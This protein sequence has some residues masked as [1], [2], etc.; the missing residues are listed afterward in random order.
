MGHSSGARGWNGAGRRRRAALG[1]AAI[2][3][4]V[5]LASGLTPPPLRAGDLTQDCH[6]WASASGNARI[7][8]ANQLG[9]DHLLTKNTRLAESDPSKPVELYRFGDLQRLC[10]GT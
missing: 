4:G 2:G 1:P 8:V 6:R 3:L 7:A 10:R 9:A 5:A